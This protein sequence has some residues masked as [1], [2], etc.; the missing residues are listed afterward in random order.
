MH[1]RCWESHGVDINIAEKSARF[2]NFRDFERV[3]KTKIIALS[4]YDLNKTRLITVS[5]NQTDSEGRGLLTKT[6]F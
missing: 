2:H 3:V 4:I 5:R 1:V 6:D